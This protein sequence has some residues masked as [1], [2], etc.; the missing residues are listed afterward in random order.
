MVREQEADSS[1]KEGVTQT[2]TKRILGSYNREII[3]SILRLSTRLEEMPNQSSLTMTF[4]KELETPIKPTWTIPSTRATSSIRLR[5]LKIFW[6]STSMTLGI[7]HTINKH[8]L[9]VQVQPKQKRRSL[10]ISMLI[11]VAY[12]IDLIKIISPL[13]RLLIIHCSNWRTNNRLFRE[14]KVRIIT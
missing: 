14:L 5:T 4:C 13:S 6:T 11:W 12:S 1:I 10:L 7:F 2:S 8:I 3:I 9:L